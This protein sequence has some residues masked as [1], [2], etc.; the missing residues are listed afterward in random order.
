MYANAGPGLDGYRWLQI[1]P[2][3]ILDVYSLGY[4][5]NGDAHW[6]PEG[7]SVALVSPEPGLPPA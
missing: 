7:S 1:G 2:F 6:Y 4:G 5:I 3:R